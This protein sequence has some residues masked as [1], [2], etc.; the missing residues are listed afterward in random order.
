[1][2]KPT[3]LIGIPTAL[4]GRFRPFDVCVSKLVAYVNQTPD[5]PFTLA[6]G[7]PFWA[8]T[9]VVPAARNRIVREALRQG[10]DYIWWLDDDQPFH[11]HDLEKLFAHKLDAVLPLSPRRNAPFQPLLND[12]MDDTGH[13]LQ[14]WLAPH[15]SGLIAVAS[16][17]MA[18]LLI[19]TSCFAAL[20]ADGWFEFYHPPTNFDDYAED[21]PFYRKLAASGVQLYCDLDVRFGHQI[22]CVAY[23]VKQQGAWVTV[24]AD[25]EP[26]CAFPQPS[27]P[28]GVTPV[29]MAKPRGKVVLV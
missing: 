14:H 24:L 27:H 5:L 7:E 28:L 17:G 25:Q 15:E 16:A 23:L 2:P 21:Y 29:G 9:G 22:S 26:F 13:A 18:G 4:G 19:K 8:M 6:G 12:R 10:A 1:M 20:G 11:P 3:I